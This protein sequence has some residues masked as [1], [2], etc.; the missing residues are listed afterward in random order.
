MGAVS[1]LSRDPEFY[2]LVMAKAGRIASGWCYELV[3]SVERRFWASMPQAG[4]ERAVK[5]VLR[6]GLKNIQRDGR[7]VARRDGPKLLLTLSNSIFCRSVSGNGPVCLYYAS[8]FSGL[9]EEAG[10]RWSAVVESSCGESNR[11]E[12]RFEASS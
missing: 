10:L 3:S 7:L 6:S 9:M 2:T 12:C 8:L 11:T 1:Y 5:R 4:R